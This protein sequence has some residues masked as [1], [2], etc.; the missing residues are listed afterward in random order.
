MRL[1]QKKKTVY[2]DV[3]PEDVRLAALLAHQGIDTV[4]DIGANVGQYAT[5]LRKSGFKG[6]IV[7]FEPLGKN[8]EVLESVSADDS[9]WDIAAP[10][11]IGEEDGTIEINISESHEMSSILPLEPGTLTAL[12]KAKYIGT[13]KVALHTLDN[14]LDQYIGETEKLF[15][16]AD[17]QGFEFAVLKGAA[18]S[19]AQNKIA[20]WQ[21]ELSLLPLY[22]GE[23]TLEVLMSWLKERSFDPH[24]VLP[25]YFSKKL[26][27]QLQIDIIFFKAS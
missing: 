26:M 25:G 10:M 23:P 22:S 7:S 8:H 6:R 18:E 24:F 11:A 20:G 15:I 3:T 21:L 14:I 5:R 19:I 4:F 12:P 13:E 9:K 1:F 27:R 2:A 16:K 17:T